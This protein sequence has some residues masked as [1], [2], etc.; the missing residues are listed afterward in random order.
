MMRA[1]REERQKVYRRD[2]Q[3]AASVPA[4][5]V[6]YRRVVTEY[7]RTPMAET[8]W[9][10]LGQIYSDTKRY[11]LAAGAFVTLGTRFPSTRF[12]AWFAA[13]ELYDKRLGDKARAADAYARVPA[14]SPRFQ[15]AQKRARR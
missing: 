4:A 5:L 7:G 14:S 10:R 13:A 15:D 8:A 3:L 12:D 9:W 2:E 11:A 6:T 1:E